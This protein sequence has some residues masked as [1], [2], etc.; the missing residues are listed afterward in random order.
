[1][2]AMT[3][4][5]GL[6]PLSL[7]F[8][9]VA[10]AA[11]PAQAQLGGFMKRAVEK[12]VG[13]KVDDQANIAMLVEPRFDETTVELTA[14]RLDVYIAAMEKRKGTAAA[15][16]ARANAIRDRVS[17]LQDSARML[18]R[19]KEEEAF[20][21]ATRRYHD[22]R[23]GVKQALD[24]ASEARMQQTVMQFQSN[25]TGAQKDPK[26]REMMAVMQ[27]VA[28]A[29]QKGDPEAIQ[30][31]QQRYQ[32]L[33]NQVT[34]SG[35][36]DKAAAP[37][38]GPRPTQPESMVRAAAYRT[39][40]DA[41]QKE[42][43]ALEGSSAGVSGAAVGLTDVQAQMEWERIQSWLYGMRPEYPISVT[44][45]RVEYDQLVAHRSPLRKAFS[46]S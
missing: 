31:A 12:R 11:A 36:I 8:C 27:Q 37:K 4:R 10:L 28:A 32:A 43:E 39:R 42:A 33:F 6:G 16:R 3:I 17:A 34:D 1:M 20:D 44:F 22:C 19:P 18:A 30:K 40:A 15:D 23:D 9:L 29:Q 45:T 46:G 21:N 5:S 35:A 13:Q 24:K 14:A 2:R 41:D 26:V 25:P 38:C 7:S